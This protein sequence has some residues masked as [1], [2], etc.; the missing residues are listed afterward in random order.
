MLHFTRLPMTDIA[1]RCGFAST[2]HHFA[3]TFKKVANRTALEYRKQGHHLGLA[4][5]TVFAGASDPA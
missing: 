3:D 5:G 1:L 4:I 2:S